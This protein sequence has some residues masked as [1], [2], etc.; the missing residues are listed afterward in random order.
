MILS[1]PFL[2]NKHINIFNMKKLKHISFWLLFALGMTAMVFTACSEDDP[3]T[4]G[5]GNTGGSTDNSGTSD[6][7]IAITGLSLDS[8][9]LT[10]PVGESFTLATTISPANATNVTITWAIS[11]NSKA[12]VYNGTVTAIAIGSAIITA[13]AGD[14]T[15]SCTITITKRP[16]TKINADGITGTVTDTEGNRYAIVKIGDQWWMADNLKTTKIQRQ[17]CNTKCS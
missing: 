13:T 11:D 5:D 4:K 1:R 15:D 12:Y 10:L 7:T 8:T 16:N 17:Y 14:Q 2:Y 9:T 3:I 6:S